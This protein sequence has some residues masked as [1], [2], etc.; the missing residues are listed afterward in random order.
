MSQQLTDSIA[1]QIMGEIDAVTRRIDDLQGRIQIQ[2]KNQGFISRQIDVAKN[3]FADTLNGLITEAEAL[4]GRQAAF[5]QDKVAVSMAHIEE[6]ANTEIKLFEIASKEKSME[7]IN[8]IMVSAY[9]ARQEAVDGVLEL[10][11]SKFVEALDTVAVANKAFVEVRGLFINELVECVKNAEKAVKKY[12]LSLQISASQHR[13]IGVLEFFS[14]ALL[15]STIS[16]AILVLFMTYRAN[17]V[18]EQAALAVH[19]AKFKEVYSQ[20]DAKT[21]EKIIKLWK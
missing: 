21:Q 6:K 3:Q 7:E 18:P 12:D 5:I 10:I 13:S 19:G 15:A 20:L 2:L 14:F 11:E 17:Q 4:K 8:A 16:A 1:S 9:Q